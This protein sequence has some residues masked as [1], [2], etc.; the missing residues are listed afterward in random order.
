MQYDRQ[1]MYY[2]TILIIY[3]FQEDNLKNFIPVFHLREY[4]HAN[5]LKNEIIFIIE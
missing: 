5:V 2:I 1:T 4:T 3:K